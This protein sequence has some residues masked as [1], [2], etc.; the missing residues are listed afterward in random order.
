VNSLLTITIQ[1]VVQVIQAVSYPL[2]RWWASM[3]PKSRTITIAV[4][5]FAVWWDDIAA[6][7]GTIP[8]TAT[9]FTVGLIAA[10][11][12][13]RHRARKTWM[14]TR[15]DGRGV[16][17]GPTVVLLTS[18]AAEHIPPVAMA[19]MLTQAR[20]AGWGRQSAEIRAAITRLATTSAQT[21]HVTWAQEVT[22]ATHN[23]GTWQPG[24][25][26]HWTTPPPMTPPEP[27]LAGVT[28]LTRRPRPTTNTT[29][30]TR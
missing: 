21:A 4:I 29:R 2:R 17:A 6:V 23:Q 1:L 12:H 13:R 30:G 24:W 26:R 7:T 14:P 20:T 3:T 18:M 5:A 15:R 9:C 11:R 10:L 25:M 8:L 19:R 16:V 28:T 27:A 22:V